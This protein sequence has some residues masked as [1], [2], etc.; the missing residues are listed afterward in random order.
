MMNRRLSV[1]IGT[2]G[3]IAAGC[4]AGGTHIST[5]HMYVM[6]TRCMADGDTYRGR[7]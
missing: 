3:A 5:F 6:R 2:A 1:R 7:D 4:G